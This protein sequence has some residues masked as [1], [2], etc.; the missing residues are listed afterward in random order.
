[1]GERGER[2]LAL[3]PVAV[4]S[5]RG[6]KVNRHCPLPAGHRPPCRVEYPAR[7]VA[8]EW[9]WESGDDGLRQTVWVGGTDYDRPPGYGWADD[10]G[11]GEMQP[12]EGPHRQSQLFDLDRGTGMGVDPG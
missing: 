4:F 6:R 3:D 5:S 10:R 8:I 2:C 11:A 12:A 7:G 9:I 1:M